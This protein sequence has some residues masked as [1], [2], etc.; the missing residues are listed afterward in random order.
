MLK[1]STKAKTLTSLQD[2]IVKAKILDI[3][4]F[5]VSQWRSNPEIVLN[6]IKN[7]S[8]H[9]NEMIVRSSS[10]LEDSSESSCAGLFTSLLKITYEDLPSAISE[11]IESFINCDENEDEILIQPM[12]PNVAISGVI[13][14]RDPNSAIPIYIINYDDTGSTTNVTQGNSFSNL[15]SYYHYKDSHIPPPHNL[16]PIFDLTFELESIFSD[17]ALDI[18]F[19]S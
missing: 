13:F 4:S 9:R 19:W 2:K 16:Q 15:K 5:T 18:E 14:N 3:V 17:Q 10:R 8:W 6:K 7:Y 12:L 1:L 11:V